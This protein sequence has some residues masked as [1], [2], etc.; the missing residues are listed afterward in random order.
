MMCQRIALGL[1]VVTSTAFTTCQAQ[2]MNESDVPTAVMSAFQDKYPD[3]KDVEWEKE[4]ATE[5]EAE[6]ELND[7][8]MS[9]NFSPDGTW[10]ETETEIKKEDL[11]EA[12]KS[13]LKSEFADYEV[14]EVEKVATLEQAEA[15]EAE[16]EKDE[17]TL[18]LL[19]DSSGKVLKQETAEEDGE[20]GE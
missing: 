2:R 10:L 9:A 14:E 19:L 13:T 8:E 6:F 20:D 15:Y 16:P 5:M 4:S 17:T 3:A 7:E 12:V 18:E 11:P 1:A